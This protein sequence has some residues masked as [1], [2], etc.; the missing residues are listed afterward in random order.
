MTDLSALGNHLK[1][2]AFGWT[3]LD[4]VLIKI[5]KKTIKTTKEVTLS[6]KL[7]FFLF[8]FLPILITKILHLFLLKLEPSFNIALT[9]TRALWTG[10]F[11]EP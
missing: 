5:K 2:K 10:H 7:Q 6:Q 3:F 11:M 1:T 4:L 8:K 9:R